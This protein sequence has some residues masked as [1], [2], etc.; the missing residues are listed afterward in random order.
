MKKHIPFIVAALA[1]LISILSLWVFRGKSAYEIAVD[2]GFI[3]SEAEWLASLEGAQGEK[4]EK[5]DKGDTGE[6]G[7]TGD[8]GLTGWEGEDG[9]D[10]I[11]GI[12]GKNGID[13]TNVV[14]SYVDER[15]HLILELSD[16][17]VV[18]AGYIGLDKGDMGKEPTLSEDKICLAPKDIYMLDTNLDHPVWSSSDPNVVRVGSNGL[19]LGINEGKA[20]V[21]ATSVDGKTA[22]CEITVLQ[23][24][25]YLNSEGG[26]VITSYGGG[27][28]VVEIPEKL[29]GK[30][31][32]EI[33]EWAFFDSA[34]EKVV[35][36]DSVKTIGYGAFSTCNYLKEID[37]GTGLESIGTSAFSDCYSLTAV[38]LPESLTHLG[39]AAFFGCTSLGSIVIPSGVTTVQNA[40]FNECRS[41]SEVVMGN[42]E[43]INDFAFFAC[44]SLEHV[45][46][47]ESLLMIGESAFSGCEKLA[48]V[49]FGNPDTVYGK[50]AF[51][52]CIFSPAFGADGFLPVNVTMYTVSNATARS[53]PSLDA[54]AITWPSKGSAINVI[55]MDL[56]N[57]WAKVS[58]NGQ[59]LY[60]RSTLLAFTPDI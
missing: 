46:L 32:T 55:G 17:T 19:I 4:G 43:F 2:N 28:S 26:A 10:G 16:G 31:V 40:T 20:T 58:V 25:Y 15:S 57:E 14:G 38:E 12:D 1:L 21:T 9:K 56:D 39:N 22:S 11:D 54:P 60:I 23:L 29:G 52:G 35:L 41:L 47:P 33:D 30:P 27:L 48:S 53:A 13:G 3:G 7:D 34:V 36:P 59:P 5:G 6:K 45:S 49:S 8:R 44:T 42:V 24:E 50:N 18:D 51:E 37:L